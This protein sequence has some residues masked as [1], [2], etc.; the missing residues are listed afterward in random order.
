MAYD[1]SSLSHSDFED[2]ARDLIGSEIGKRFEAFPEGPDDGMDGRHALADGAIVLQAKHYYRTGFSGLKSKMAKERQ[3]IER[4]V[5]KRYILVTSAP[6]T[7][8]NKS[9]LAEIIGPSLQTPG[10]I[11]GPGDLNALL[12]KH[13]NIEKAHQKLWAQ[14]TSVLETVVTEAVGKALAKPEPIPAVLANLL[15]PKVAAGS[16]TT[17]ENT[18][19]DT[20]FLIKSSPIDDEF[21]LWLAPKL[22]AEGYRV[23]ADILTLQPGDRWRRQIN[24]ALQYRA[25]KVLL[26][27]RDATLDDPHVQDDLD[28][29][30][31]LSKEIPD[32][33][34]IIPLR[35][36][37]G[38]KVKGVGDAVTVDFVRGWGDGAGLLLD[39]LQRQK[40]LRSAGPPVIDPNWEI[41]RRRGAIPLV[42]EAERLT[43][44]WLR[45]A[46]APDV[47]R[48]FESTGAIE[49]RL[50]NRALE[51][52]PYPCA[53]QGSGIITFADEAEIDV[54]FASVGRFKLKNEIP[55]LEFVDNG[56]PTLGMERQVASNLVIAMIK[57][58]WLS[59][60]REKGFVEYHYS[61][62]AGFHASATQAQIG[63]R[64]PWG[65]QGDR[66][67][68]MLRN[69]AKGHIWQF[70]V[71]AMPHFWP[72]W[73]LK[74]KSRVL[75]SVDNDTPEGLVIDDARK[76][77]RLRRSICKGWR[78][79]Q[80]RGRMLAFLEL[81]SGE[82][83]YIR[84]SLSTNAA[85]VIEATPMLFTSPVCTA[86][87]DV[88]DADEEEADISTLGRPDNDDEV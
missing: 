28:I 87:P 80:W 1:F 17:V 37:A 36:E 18:V 26:V 22:E 10:D 47:I 46:E 7:P 51:A 21:T 66:R 63:Q 62:A 27:C 53:I 76:L 57:K 74:L 33:R 32:S 82:S 48:Y 25:A 11:F 38:K 4:L 35:L 2:L 56:F 72:F 41:F 67:S 8:K 71:T 77:H 61:N 64:I 49:Q 52:F 83:A 5:P 55:L 58:A 59:F 73:H 12:R 31:E 79:K 39:T 34:F 69:V 24:Q 45:A 13:P 50:L 85:I 65:K 78:N 70:G 88:L 40:V 43:S 23:F 81:L 3:S 6:L 60:C 30:L 29:A 15:P 19:R 16:A 75:F 86:L 44:N 9:A 84:L 14:S 68:S 20:I 42:E 54:A